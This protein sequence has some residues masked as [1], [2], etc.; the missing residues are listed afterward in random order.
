MPSVIVRNEQHTSANAHQEKTPAILAGALL[1]S[2]RCLAKP[3]SSVEIL[4]PP[5]VFKEDAAR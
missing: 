3:A 4:Q 1:R 2:A 5:P